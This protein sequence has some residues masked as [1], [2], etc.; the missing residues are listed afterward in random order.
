MEYRIFIVQ[1][2]N[3]NDMHFFKEQFTKLL[4]STHSQN[5]F[6]CVYIG[7]EEQNRLAKCL[8]ETFEASP[9]HISGTIEEE[10][11]FDL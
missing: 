2:E 11:T 4:N 7:S 8:I 1:H 3:C 5:R 6:Q 10:K 9:F